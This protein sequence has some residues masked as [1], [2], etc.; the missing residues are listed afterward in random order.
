[1]KFRLWLIFALVIVVPSFVL[2]FLALR[3]NLVEEA[4]I[5]KQLEEIVDKE[6]QNITSIVKDELK[7]IETELVSL[8]ESA[9]H[10]KEKLN[11][12]SQRSRLIDIPFFLNTQKDILWPNRS[13]TLTADDEKFLKWH[14]EFFK[15]K[16]S[17]PVFK[18]I[19]FVYKDII[20]EETYASSSYIGR[21]LNSVKNSKA[22]VDD[23]ENQLA[24]QQFESD[25]RVRSK[26]YKKARM[27]KQQLATRNVEST[28][29][30]GQQKR[31]NQ[32]FQ[33]RQSKFV[34]E[35][36]LFS[37]IISQSNSGII[38]KLVEER[39]Q[40]LFWSKNQK[41]EIVGCIINREE[42]IEHIVKMLPD[43]QIYS[44]ERI[45]T[46]L[47]EL[48]QPL[49]APKEGVKHDWRSPFIAHELSVY[50]PHWEVAA[51]LTDPNSILTRAN[52][53]VILIGFVV[54]GLVLSIVMGG[55]FV[56]RSMYEQ[57]LL[58]QQKTTFV[59]N[60]SHEL[61]TPL[62]SIR[63]FAE[64][65]KENRQ[66]DE[67]KRRHYLDIMVSESERLTRLINNVLDF[68][69]LGQKNKR[70]HFAIVDIVELC[71]DVV[72]G[73]RP[74]LEHNGFQITFKSRHKHL[75]IS[76]DSESIKQ[77]L[78]NLLSNAE[79]Y[80]DDEKSIELEI[81]DDD[82]DVY[83]YVKD[84]GIGISSKFKDKIFDEFYRVDDQLT[85]R[86][87]GTGLGLTIAQRIMKDHHGAIDYISREQKGSIFRINIP[88]QEV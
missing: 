29:G 10:S 14:R 45:I 48:G 56:L 18:N 47:D 57:V 50:L 80:S 5:E 81:D 13:Q 59:A 30:F 4:V 82:K 41:G 21:K 86:K 36:V 84:L 27:D 33:P 78:L 52:T 16:E 67:K 65:L 15:D 17:T 46:I 87:S 7:K 68:A 25:V 76:V 35:A 64:M 60:V 3:T 2:S 58:A 12:I 70:Y 62:T 23:I 85:S 31:Y 51:Y 71:K 69:S 26:V 40:L 44:K 73:Q 6:L 72:E 75:E 24:L 1:M 11:L 20:L 43:A 49:I 53:K 22:P 9:F 39:L 74:R 37:D 55:I 77:V 42:M 38:P 19:A 54:Y 32:K 61:K 34:S 79:N 28:K 88:K 83:I 63:M 66:P 8:L